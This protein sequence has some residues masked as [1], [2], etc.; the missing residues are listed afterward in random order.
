LGGEI[1]IVKGETEWA[2]QPD[3][4]WQPGRHQ[5]TIAATLED[6]AGNSVGRPFE[7]ILDGQ[8][9]QKQADTVELPFEVR[10][11]KMQ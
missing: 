3:A 7:V 2:F 10:A 8:R 4:R 5:L 1:Q 11:I 9:R 6:L